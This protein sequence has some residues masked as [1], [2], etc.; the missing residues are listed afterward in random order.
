MPVRVCISGGSLP[1]V[2]VGDVVVLKFGMERLD[3]FSSISRSKSL[4]RSVKPLVREGKCCLDYGDVFSLGKYIFLKNIQA[5]IVSVRS[6]RNI[7]S[8]LSL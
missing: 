7:L 4:V 8:S 2:Q 6:W 1:L 5:N 3:I